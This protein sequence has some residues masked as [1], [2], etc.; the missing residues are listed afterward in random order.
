MEEKPIPSWKEFREGLLSFAKQ[1]AAQRQ[2]WWFRGHSSI[3]Y[4]VEA[5]IDRGR[6]FSNDSERE[7]K[8]KDLLLEFRREAMIVTGS[9]ALPSGDDLE[10]VAR[11]HGLPSPL[12]DWT[13][14]PW[15]ASF[16]A[17][18]TADAKSDPSVAIYA[19]NRSQID[20]DV[21][22]P[23][24]S[25]VNAQLEII[26]DAER[27]RFNRRALQQRGAFLRIS[28]ISKPLT[29]L[30][31]TALARYILP[32]SDRDEVLADLDQMLLNPTN[33]MYD[34]EGAAKKAAFRVK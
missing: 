9:T 14:S 32:A 4:G 2:K 11:H 29:T 24:S 31:G 17:Y 25:K 27:L 10:L 5:T 3:K 8:I 28:T 13:L 34:L 16:F 20:S 7:R 6:I 33:L 1:D 18:I 19:L 26:D 15:I 30:L 12:L 22:A 23:A 21:L